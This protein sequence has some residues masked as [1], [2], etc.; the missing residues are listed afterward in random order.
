L[1]TGWS[2]APT[3]AGSFVRCL[4]GDGTVRE[5][6]ASD[7]LASLGGTPTLPVGQRGFPVETPRDLPRSRPALLSVEGRA[8]RWTARH[9]SSRD[10]VR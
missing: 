1:R 5:N 10:V 7:V 3:A 9:M 8:E 6:V 2:T 4:G